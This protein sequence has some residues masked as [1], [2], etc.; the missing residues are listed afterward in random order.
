VLQ[1]LKAGEESL[2]AARQD[3]KALQVGQYMLP[4]YHS[5]LCLLPHQKAG[6]L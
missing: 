1:D 4:Q 5:G 3:A 6:Q 2:E